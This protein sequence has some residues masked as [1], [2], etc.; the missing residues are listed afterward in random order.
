MTNLNKTNNWDYIKGKSLWVN[1]NF[2]EPVQINNSE[3]LSFSFN[4]F[5]LNHLSDFSINLIDDSNKPL[6]FSS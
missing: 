2:D 4:T 5:S 6:E 3:H 1:V